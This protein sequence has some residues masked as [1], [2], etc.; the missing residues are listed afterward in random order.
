MWVSR[1]GKNRISGPHTDENFATLSKVLWN[2]GFTNR[3]KSHFQ[4]TSMRK[5]C[6]HE[7]WY[8]WNVDFTTRHNRIFRPQKKRKFPLFDRYLETL[9]SRIVKNRS[10]RLPK[11]GKFANMNLRTLES[12][13]LTTRQQSHFLTSKMQKI[14]KRM[15]GVPETVDFR[16]RQKSHFQVPKMKKICWTVSINRMHSFRQLTIKFSSI[17]RPVSVKRTSVSVNRTSSFRQ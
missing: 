12:F 5:I 9:L 17:D 13:G 15:L 2:I 7:A 11:C 3:K 1:L 10:F 4:L 16:T 14:S 6:S 8:P